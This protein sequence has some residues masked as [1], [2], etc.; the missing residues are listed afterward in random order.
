MIIF[1]HQNGRNTKESEKYS[2]NTKITLTMSTAEHIKH[3]LST[4]KPYHH[5]QHFPK[6]S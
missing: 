5:Q 1:I 3:T 2:N 6:I 4:N